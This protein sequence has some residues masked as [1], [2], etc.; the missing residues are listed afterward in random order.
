MQVS[1]HAGLRARQR[2]I[3]QEHVDIIMQY[4]T[5]V[6]KPGRAFE[7]QISKKDRDR[8]IRDLKNL[9]K[10]VEKCSSTALLVDRH[11]GTVITMYNH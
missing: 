9:I 7:I 5:P 2:G 4:G 10:T 6:E 11:M 1:G 3:P 8:I